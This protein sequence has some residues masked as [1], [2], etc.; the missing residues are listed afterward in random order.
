M[1]GLNT[2]TIQSI[3]LGLLFI[4]KKTSSKDKPGSQGAAAG[5]YRAV[6]RQ[7]LYISARV[8]A[9]LFSF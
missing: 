7:N 9:I 4:F 1:D 2:M 5:F 3:L 8:Y 6:I